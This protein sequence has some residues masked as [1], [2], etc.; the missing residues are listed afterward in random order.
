MKTIKILA[1]ILTLAMSL[2]LAAC[3]ETLP[4]NDPPANNQDTNAE[5]PDN[6]TETPSAPS[7][8]NG[9][10]TP[11]YLPESFKTHESDA[12]FF[13][14]ITDNYVAYSYEIIKRYDGFFDENGNWN[15]VDAGGNYDAN[16]N[17]VENELPPNE[18]TTGYVVYFFDDNDFGLGEYFY[19]ECAMLEPAVFAKQ[20]FPST[21]KAEE[22]Y[23]RFKGE[24]G[25]RGGGRALILVDDTV[26]AKGMSCRSLDIA[27]KRFQKLTW[28]GQDVFN[29]TTKAEFLENLTE[30]FENYGAS[31]MTEFSY[32]IYVS[33]P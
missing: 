5:P 19:P 22:D 10:N 1:L 4:N 16:G 31:E 8:N 32:E 11:L 24:W 28:H 18:T 27:D 21:D 23:S 20:T 2:T 15:G 17:W 26:Y 9:G 6:G 14:A 30:T 13:Y 33:Q 12:E 25:E 29:N 3:G 7:P